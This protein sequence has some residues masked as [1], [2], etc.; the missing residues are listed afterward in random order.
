[1]DQH[2]CLFWK[3]KK[4][5]FE[6]IELRETLS[7]SRL[8]ENFIEDYSN[9]DISTN[10]HIYNSL[11]TL[12]NQ[13]HG[14]AWS[15]YILN[16][17]GHDKV[18]KQV[19]PFWNTRSGSHLILKSR[20]F[21]DFELK[22]SVFIPSGNLDT[23]GIAFRYIDQYTHYIL[24]ISKRE[25]GYKRISKLLNGERFQI[26]NK[27][28]GGYNV[29]EWLDIKVRGINSKFKIYTKTNGLNNVNQDY[30]KIF[31]FNDNSLMHGTVAFT[32]LMLNNL[33]ID[34]ISVIQIN[35]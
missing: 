35:C 13:N 17:D 23:F 14:A 2:D 29:D 25:N 4:P 30:Q 31:D 9:Q 12:N 15:Y 28:D 1:M 16:L 26:E 32:S 24:E 27:D 33:M 19:G 21:Y 11:N 8:R 7:E 5:E 18:I 3:Y 6:L 10:Y 22:F 20:E 34:N